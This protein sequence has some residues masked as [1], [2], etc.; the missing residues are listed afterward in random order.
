MPRLAA[1]SIIDLLDIT[2]FNLEVIE[3]N[4]IPSFLPEWKYACGQRDSL[5]GK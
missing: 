5:D 2:T 3:T 1:V 4:P